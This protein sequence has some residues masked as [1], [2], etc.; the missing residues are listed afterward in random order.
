ME[1]PLVLIVEDEK[2]IRT[3]LADFLDFHGF[4]AVQAVDGLEAEKAVKEERFDVILLDLM[5]PKI[6][7]EKLCEKWRREGLNTPVIM[8]TAKGQEKDRINGLELGA[9]DYV[10]KP[11]S[12]EELLARIKAILRRTDP[13]RKVGTSFRLGDWEVDVSAMTIKKEG[14]TAEI[15]KRESQMIQYFAA[16]PGRVISREELYEAVWGE[17]MSELGTRTTD[18]HIAKLRAK[19]ETDPDEPRII[20]TVRGAGY[21]YEPQP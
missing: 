16:N 9:D 15:S 10:T 8:L 17:P 13:K 21:K 1:K 11:F 2:A 3:A 12:L 4:I 5:L 7:G 14:A 19:I 6:S 20:K 18:M